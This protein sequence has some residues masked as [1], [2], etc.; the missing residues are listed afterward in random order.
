[1]KL[2][3]LQE[4][5][6]R[7]EPAAILVSPRVLDRVLRQEHRLRSLVSKVPHRHCYVVDRHLLFRHV[8]QDELDLEP[9]RLLPATVILLARPSPEELAA[10]DDK[11]LLL[12]YWRRLFHAEVHLALQIRCEEGELFAADVRKRIDQIGPVAFE[13]IRRVL[14]EDGLLPGNADDR[15]VYIEFVAAYL[16]LHYFAADLLPAYFPALLDRDR[17]WRLLSQE[18]DSD[19]LFARSRLAGAPDPVSRRD[20]GSDE[21][22]DYYWKL[23]AAAERATNS[24]NTVRAAILRTRAARVAPAAYTAGT[25]A[26]AQANLRQLVDRLQAALQLTENEAAEWLKDL[27]ALLDK[28]D[29][30]SRPVEAALLYDLQTV[31]QDHERDIYALDLVEWLLSVGRRPIKR[32]LPSQRVVHI[33]KHLRSAA[34]LLARARLSDADRQHFARLLQAAMQLIEGRL[35]DRFRPILTETFH[36]VG[37]QPTNPPER[38]AFLKMVEELLDRIA[39]FGFLTFSDLRDAISRNQLKLPDLASPEDFVR[40]DPLLQLDRRLATLLDGVYRRAEIYLRGLERFTAINFGTATGRAVTLFLTVPFGGAFLLLEAIRLLLSFVGGPSVPTVG[41]YSVTDWTLVIAL[42]FFLLGLIHAP[43]FRR[44]CVETVF[45]MGRI[46]RLTFIDLPTR[47]LST[48][49]VQQII[50]SWPFRLFT[51]YLIKPLVVCAAIWYWLPEMFSTWLGASSTFLAINF[52]L[53]SRPGQEVGEAMLHGLVKFYD[54]LRAGLLPGLFRLIVTGFKR[55]SQMLE[56]VLFSVDEWLRFRNGDS[57]WSMAVRIVGGVLWFPISYVA[58]FYMVVLIEPGINPIKFPVSSLAAKFLYPWL[59]LKVGLM[60]EQLSP[61]MGPV[62][63]GLFVGGT[64]WLLPDVF[65]FLFWEMKENWSLYRANRNPALEPAVVGVHGETVRRLL[66]PGFHSGT[67]PKLYARLR[68]AERIGVKTGNWQA[69]RVCARDL[70]ENELALRRFLDREAVALVRQSS[71]WKGQWLRA[72]R[73]V[74]ASNRI[75]LELVHPEHLDRP[76]WLD[77]ENRSGWL[78]AGLRNP[79]WLERVSPPQRQAITIALIGFYKRAGVELV[80]EQIEASLPPEARGY[81]ITSSALVL[82]LGSHGGPAIYYDWTN[83]ESRLFAHTADGTALSQWPPLEPRRILFGRVAI[84][85]SQWVETWQKDQD[86]QSPPAPFSVEV[87]LLPPGQ[88]ALD[89]PL[90]RSEISVEPGIR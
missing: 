49:V 52:V 11:P 64:V 58:R 32:P 3:E 16:E 48:A 42:G 10:G 31:C 19:S 77:L 78:V 82:W 37:F 80:R 54:L 55:A 27:P 74:L 43:D 67:L 90:L 61:I 40:G 12:K 87:K 20:D 29:Q 39:S 34:Q 15:T 14:T 53:N 72:G 33:T 41:N 62:A 46:L 57:R 63:A 1:M 9:E 2:S 18:V 44:K 81:D 25:R 4:E 86:G 24:G 84:L 71:H 65:G 28:A 89:A 23:I 5:L 38:T 73:V 8:E 79:G 75:S 6:R 59:A 22:H 13:E 69:A 21:S 30:G 85:W 68:Y 35:R 88:T 50:R 7:A 17:V 66:Q 47:V 26:Q 83:A 70:Q 45:G 36:D 51:G 60:V 56:Y 76:I